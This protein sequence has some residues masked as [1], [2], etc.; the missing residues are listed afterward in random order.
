[1]HREGP[2]GGRARSLADPAAL[3]Y[4]FPVRIPERVFPSPILGMTGYA[5]DTFGPKHWAYLLALAFAW[6]G[7]VWVGRVGLSPEVRKRV[8]LVLAVVSLGQELLDDL[9]RASR[10]VWEL[11]DDLPLHLCSLAMLVG[12]WALLTKGQRVFEVAYYWGL[13]AASQAILTPDNSRWQMGELDVFWNFLSHGLVISN[14]LW[15]VFVEGKRCEPGSWWRV[16]LVTNVALVPIALINL[17][18]ASNYF[19]ICRKPGGSSPFLVGEWPWYILGFEVLA[20]AFFWVF[21]LPMGWDA[22]RRGPGPLSPA[23]T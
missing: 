22:R 15:L 5:F 16:F 17:A 3:P 8:V 6:A 9:I 23:E 13:V 19:F 12:V 20:L 2:P 21:S 11:N 10:G 4:S 1:M 18:M 14:V 7:V